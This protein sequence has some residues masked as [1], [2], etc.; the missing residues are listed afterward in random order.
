MEQLLARLP[1]ALPE[2]ENTWSHYTYVPDK[3][4]VIRVCDRHADRLR[5]EGHPVTA[6]P[7][8]VSTQS[9]ARA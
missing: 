3:W 5:D 7:I 6:L 8:L 1:C 9:P 2:C 4:D